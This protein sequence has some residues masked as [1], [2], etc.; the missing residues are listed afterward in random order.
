[1]IEEPGEYEFYVSY[2]GVKK[3]GKVI[4]KDTTSPTLEIRNVTIVEGQS[5]DASSFVESCHDLSGCNYS[6][7]DSETE[8]KY[9]TPGS[10]VVYVVATDAFQNTTTKKASLI[11]ESQG[12][13]HVFKRYTSFNWNLGYETYETYDLHFAKFNNYS[14]LING[15]YEKEMIYQDSEKYNNE[16]KNLNGE[17]NY[18]FN[19]AEMTIIE[20]KSVTLIG[21][22]YSRLEDIEPYLLKEGFTKE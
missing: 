9:Q 5:Y 3:S 8:L 12:N 2:K 11:I 22:N 1:M 10:Y 4:V 15:T 19:D 20:K 7:Q 18:T 21:S 16:K 17:V 13:V 14:L 6:F